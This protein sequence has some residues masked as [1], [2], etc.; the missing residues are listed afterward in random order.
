MLQTD[1]KV[2]ASGYQCQVTMNKEVTRCGFNSLTYGHSWPVWERGLELT[3]QECRTAVETGV[4]TIEQRSY[5]VEVGRGED[6]LLLQPRPR[7]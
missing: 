2:P 6:G 4:I 7:R 3:P 5:N 1:T